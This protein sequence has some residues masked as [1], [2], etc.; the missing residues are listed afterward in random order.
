MYDFFQMRRICCFSTFAALRFFPKFGGSKQRYYFLPL[1]HFS[2]VINCPQKV[3]IVLVFQ[4]ALLFSTKFL[5]FSNIFLLFS[6]NFLLFSTNFSSPSNLT[7][8]AP[9]EQI[10]SQSIFTSM[11]TV[12]INILD[13]SSNPG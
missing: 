8:F 2:Y 12:K 11:K 13:I 9:N 4:L 5:L 10:T 3:T 6:S 1:A 7:F